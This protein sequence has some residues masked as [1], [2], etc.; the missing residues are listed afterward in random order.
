MDGIVPTLLQIINVHSVYQD[1]VPMAAQGEPD[2]TLAVEIACM[3][4]ETTLALNANLDS[5]K[6]PPLLFTTA[7]QPM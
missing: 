5:F 2:A 3:L 4:Q 6:L 7:F 1:L